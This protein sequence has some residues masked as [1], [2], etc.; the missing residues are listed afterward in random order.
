MGQRL[1]RVNQLMRK[2]ISDIL[3]TDYCAETVCIT[4]TEVDVSPNLRCAR[5]YFSVIG[6]GLE[7]RE[8]GRFLK[9]HAASI[10]EKLNKRIILK[11]SPKLEFHYDP[12]IQRGSEMI[13][14]MNQVD[15]E[16]RQ[17]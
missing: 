11:Y 1:V 17:S 2:E 3:H 10:R 13:D 7:S 5:V 15:L 8:A 16:D 14:F 6:K 12:S 9:N 4:I